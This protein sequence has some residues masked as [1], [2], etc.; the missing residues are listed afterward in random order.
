MVTCIAPALT[1]TVSGVIISEVDQQ[2][3]PGASI[4]VRNATTGTITD[5]DGKFSI[6]ANANDSLEVSFLGFETLIVKVDLSSVM[7]LTLTEKKTTLSEVVIMGYS[8]KTQKELT[9]SVS[10]LKADKLTQISSPNV[11]NM[12]QGQVAGLTVSSS[13]GQPGTAADIRIRG[14]TSINADKPPLF[15]VDGMIGGN[16]VPNDVESLT[17]LKDAAAIG[18]YGS[19]GSAGVIIVTTKQGTTEKPIV[20]FTARAGVK[21]AVTGNFQMM[22]GAQ[23]YEAQA[24][25]WGDNLVSFLSNRPEDLE[26]LNYDWLDAGFERAPLQN[27]N[28]SV[29]GKTQGVTYGFSADYYD[30]KGTFINTDYQRLNLNGNLKFNINKKLSFHTDINAQFTEDNVNFYSWFEDVFWNMPWD[31]PYDSN[32]EL[33]GPKYVTNPSNDWYGQFRRSYLYSADYNELG[34]TGTSIVWSNRAKY[35]I[36]SWL[37]AEVRTRLDAYNFSFSEYYAPNTDEGLATNGFVGVNNGGG[38]GI[39]S[40]HFLRFNKAYGSHN[41]SAF[42][43]HE[44]G[45][46]TSNTL[47]FAGQNLSSATIKVPAGASEIITS[48][49]GFGISYS[50]ISYISEASYSFMNKYF[51]NAYYRRDGSSLFAA[52]K[53]FGNFYGGSLGW[54]VSEEGFLASSDLIDIFKLRVSYGLTGNSNIPP[55]LD[56]A[57]YNITRNY[58][59]QPA[60]EPNNPANPFLGWET[61]K[62]GNVGFDLEILRSSIN[63]SVDLY[64]KSVEGM[65]LNNPLPFSS[66]Y[67]SRT[68]NIGDM[69]N[70]GIEAALTYQKSF[71]DF[72]YSANVNFAFNQNEIT[73]ITDVLDQQTVQAG[74]IQQINI[75]GQEAFQWYMPKWIGVNPD[76]GTPLW[77]T[78]EYDEN[79]NET[80]RGTTGN[81]N[82]ADFQA[83]GSA[84]P[85]L[86]G[87]I[88]NNFSYKGIGLSFLFTFQGGND[89]YHYTREFVDSDGANTGIN[90]MQLQDGWSRWEQ[91]GDDATHPQLKRGGNNGA[92]QTSSRYIEDGSFVR[93]RNVTL[94]YSLPGKLLKNIGMRNATIGINADNLWTYTQFS[95]MDPD[96]GLS[97][98]SYTLPGLSYLKYPISKQYAISFTAEF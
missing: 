28:L 84:L 39:S 60:G 41:F 50:G 55:Y 97:V 35:D 3:L 44:G 76:D 31:N 27:Y 1:Q 43:A 34:S 73:K 42:V 5:I 83:V 8:S 64:Q 72:K 54:L 56:L 2:P 57:T 67:Q 92:H 4:S 87:G 7:N 11:E 63:L 95:G 79:G 36:T 13:S 20:S 78:V 14:I 89:I 17:V 88:S 91:A 85:T 37:S 58:N 96:V 69:R 66:G 18:L 51:A 61:T 77:E 82:E 16:F 59:G 70:R 93:L 26:D 74:A 24:A 40:T 30:E 38:Y 94:S 15:V 47:N 45:Y 22:N 33:Y 75:V 21:E 49:A 23:L 71:G 80:S 81:Y 10:T 25:M 65:L 86:T 46:S 98:G 68:E 9:A 53:R 52:E 6:N 32:G 62:M 90:L 12:L 29:R 48:D 19:A